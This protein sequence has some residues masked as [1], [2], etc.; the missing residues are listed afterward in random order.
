M[1]SLRWRALAQAVLIYLAILGSAVPVTAQDTQP[2]R[3]T[4]AEMVAFARLASVAC[5]KLAPDAEAFHAFALQRLIRPPLT[6]KEI[7][8]KEK[9]V[10]QLRNRLGLTRWCRRYAS[11]MEQAR[12]LVQV[13]RR[14]AISTSP[15][16][17]QQ[18]SW[19]AQA[20]PVSIQ[21]DSGLPQGLADRSAA[22]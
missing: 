19:V 10:E 14:R 12:I 16:S 6:D 1:D 21:N 13:L 20:R 2:A 17:P 3:A 8:T 11:K 9:E 7:A 22:G 4:F 15:R 5:E 18:F